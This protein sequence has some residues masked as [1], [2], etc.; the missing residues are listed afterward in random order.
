MKT[1]YNSTIVFTDKNQKPINVF[2][3]VGELYKR[4]K[5][6][7]KEEENYII[8]Y[9]SKATKYIIIINTIDYYK[10]YVKPKSKF[11]IEYL[12]DC[13]QAITSDYGKEGNTQKADLLTAFKRVK[14]DFKKLNQ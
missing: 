3:T 9:V 4:I 6:A 8:V 14:E 5:R 12:A 1:K 10:T 11:S 7:K 2:E 13:I